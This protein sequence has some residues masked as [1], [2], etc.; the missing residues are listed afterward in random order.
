MQRPINHVPGGII[1]FC[2]VAL[3]QL[4]RPAILNSRVKLVCLPNQGYAIPDGKEC[5]ATGKFYYC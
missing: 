1:S 2:I 5:Y 4:N 3:I